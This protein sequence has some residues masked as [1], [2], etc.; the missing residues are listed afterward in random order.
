[1]VKMSRMMPPTPV[2]APW[3]G[4]TAL[5]WLCDSTLKTTASPL[6]MSSAPAFSPGPTR[7]RAPSVGSR[8][9]SGRECLYAQCSDHIAPNIPSST[10]LGMRPSAATASAYSSTLRPCRWSTGGGARVTAFSARATQR[11]VAAELE[12]DGTQRC[13]RRAEEQQQLG[14]AC[15]AEADAVERDAEPDQRDDE[16]RQAQV[17]NARD[18]GGEEHR[19]RDRD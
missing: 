4:S 1:M 10:S 17:R 7:T 19:R 14:D 12:D 11:L 15:T 2:A 13:G 16:R 6:P 8:P 18:A 5:G 9:S 3:Y